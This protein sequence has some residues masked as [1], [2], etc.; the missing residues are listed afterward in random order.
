[1]PDGDKPTE[2]PTAPASK[3]DADGEDWK[4]KYEE[5][6]AA[7]RKWEARAKENLDKAKKF[8]ELEDSQKSEIQKLTDAHQ[9]AEARAAK[10]EADALRY[11]I[12][13]RKGLS[14]VQAKRL[15]GETEE[16]LEADAEELLASF[17]TEDAG[18]RQEPPGRP[19]E[20]L[21]SGARPNDEPEPDM[22][23]VIE[24]IP[25]I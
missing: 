13:S 23:E 16:E 14:D 24:K 12:A 19:R 11:R 5:T 15:L 9:A 21:R 2:T 7:A 1:M 17:R 4:A 6:K 22:H 25:R 3:P 18:G 10:A 20:V 8:D